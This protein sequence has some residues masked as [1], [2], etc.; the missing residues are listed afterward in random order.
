MG[1]G[2]SVLIYSSDRVVVFGSLVLVLLGLCFNELE[3]REFLEMYF[4]MGRV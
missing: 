3:G 2:D 1:W 4:G